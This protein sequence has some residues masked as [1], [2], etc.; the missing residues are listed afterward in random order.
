MPPLKGNNQNRS[1]IKLFCQKTQN[2]RA[3]AALLQ[4]PQPPPPPFCRCLALRLSLIKFR[5][6]NFS[7]L[8]PSELSLMPRFKSANFYLI[9]LKLS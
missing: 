1:K 2:F 3:L 5:T 8:M 4:T 7:V 6:A 9:S